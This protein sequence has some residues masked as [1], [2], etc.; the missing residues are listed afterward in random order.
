MN[1]FLAGVL[2][3]GRAV[4]DADGHLRETGQRLNRYASRGGGFAEFAQLAGV[5]RSQ[6][7]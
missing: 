6:E 5:G 1:G 7:Q 4:L 2:L 3:K